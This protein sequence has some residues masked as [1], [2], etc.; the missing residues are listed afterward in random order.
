M[1]TSNLRRQYVEVFGPDGLE[2]DGIIAPHADE[3][4]LIAC[5][6]NRS[7]SN[8]VSELLRSTGV[9]GWAPEA[10]N[11]PFIVA[12]REQWE[13]DEPTLPAYCRR[14]RSMLSALHTRTPFVKMGWQQLFLLAD[15]GILDTVFPNRRLLLLRRR[16]LLAQGVSFSIAAE[17]GEWESKHEAAGSTATIDP[18]EI[19]ITT[20]AIH[21]R[22]HSVLGADRRVREFAAVSRDPVLEI[23][24]E[25]V[26]VDAQAMVDRVFEFMEMPTAKVDPDAVRV[27]KQR[28]PR[29]AALGQMV[30]DDNHRHLAEPIEVPSTVPE[31][32]T[33]PVVYD[34]LH[35]QARMHN[36]WPDF[37]LTDRG[38]EPP[39]E[40]LIL[41]ASARPESGYEVA[42]WLRSSGDVSGPPSFLLPNTSADAHPD[43]LIAHLRDGAEVD[44]GDRYRVKVLRPQ[45]LCWLYETRIIPHV[46]AEPKVLVVRHD[47][48][49]DAAEQLIADQEFTWDPDGEEPV[50]Q[51]VRLMAGL[52][53]RVRELAAIYGISMQ[54]VI[55]GRSV[56]DANYRRELVA[57]WLG[58]EV[59][60]L[61]APVVLMR[62]P[63]DAADDPPSAYDAVRSVWPKKMVE[64]ATH[65][66]GANRANLG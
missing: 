53:G 51:A 33:F 43:G 39:I 63:N 16:D 23:V 36:I 34:N 48:L 38:D 37:D 52:E 42:M 7:G 59:D 4:V 35:V 60:L 3:P 26:E 29:N 13:G 14:L 47:D 6:T 2:N 8:Y 15:L 5:F 45:E 57:A 21:Q 24:Y 22:I 55:I 65:Q 9:F 62:P 44:E 64:G 30:I 12:Q 58:L 61:N 31:E 10:M 27:A 18:D 32:R 46:I 54:E 28:R 25:D 19:E 17:T 50:L 20:D 40:N 1:P 41:V 11:A 56:L 49:V 66:T